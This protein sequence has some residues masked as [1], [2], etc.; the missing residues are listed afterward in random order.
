MVDFFLGV[1]LQ[2]RDD[3]YNFKLYTLGCVELF[4]SSTSENLK[5]TVLEIIKKNDININKVY[6]ITKDNGANQ[7]KAV[8]HS[9]SKS[10]Q[11][12]GGVLTT[13]IRFQRRN[14]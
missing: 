2:F 7:V 11:L 10:N 8:K 13:P 14:R 12:R 1:N 6:S 4:D 9:N 3:N 5:E